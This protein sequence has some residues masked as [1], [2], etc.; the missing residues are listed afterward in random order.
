MFNG[1][2]VAWEELRPIMAEASGGVALQE[3]VLERLLETQLRAR[4]LNVSE[5]DVA[6]EHRQ[7]IDAIVRDAG[8][9]PGDAERLLESVRRSRNLG[10]F[11]FKG[12]LWRNAALR[13]LVE[14]DVA[15]TESEVAQ[16]FEIRHGPRYRVRVLVVPTQ[17]RAAALRDELVA[18]PPPLS[19]RFA[20][21][22]MTES[23]DPSASRGGL[24]EPLSAADPGYPSS[25]REAARSLDIGE[26]SGVL[27]VDR[28]FAL[29]LVD[30]RIPAD[31]V[32]VSQVQDNILSQVRQRKERVAMDD[33]AR[34]LLG[35][36]R[37]TPMD[38]G[39]EW[40]LRGAATP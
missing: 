18:V 14:D 31:G 21:A 8:A 2:Q 13:K 17:Q 9:D 16:A 24:L 38:R 39:L 32:S 34:R 19:P 15:V 29:L 4:G 12:L 7:L 35:E 27:P 10:D 11:R 22:A 26:I 28:G 33:L 30:E 20:Q 3:V 1:H 6:K 40:S 37:I 36:A 5:A 23:S 25:I